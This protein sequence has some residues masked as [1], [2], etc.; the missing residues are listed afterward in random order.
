[1]CKPLIAHFSVCKPGWSVILSLRKPWLSRLLGLRKNQCFICF[2]NDSKRTSGCLDF[3]NNFIYGAG[4][5]QLQGYSTD[6]FTKG[7]C[8]TDGF[9]FNSAVTSIFN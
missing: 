9:K 2:L 6:G 7:V 8:A 4:N 1:M 3:E 5:K